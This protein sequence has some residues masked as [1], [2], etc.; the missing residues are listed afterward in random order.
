MTACQVHWARGRS[1]TAPEAEIEGY[2]GV[3]CKDVNQGYN[4]RFRPQG[5]SSYLPS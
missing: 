2:I 3:D 1:R 5:A 4:A